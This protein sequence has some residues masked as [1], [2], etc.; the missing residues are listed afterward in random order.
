MVNM[1]ERKRLPFQTFDTAIQQIRR[2]Y[3]SAVYFW[4]T[5][6]I[7]EDMHFQ[8]RV[9]MQVFQKNHAVLCGI[10]EALAVLRLCSGLYS[11][12]K[13]AF[14][15]FDEYVARERIIRALYAERNYRILEQEQKRQTAAE[16]ELDELWVDKSGELEIQA[17]FDGDRIEPWETIMTIKGLPQYFAH[18]ESVYLGILARRTLVATNVSKVVQAANGKDV[19]FFADRFDF[20]RNQTGD[21]YAA[22]KAGVKAV[23]TDTMGEWWGNKGAGTTPHALIASFGGDTVAATLAFARKYPDVPCISLVDFKNNCVGTSLA[24]ADAFKS[25]GLPLWGVRLDTSEA[26]VDRSISH[27]HPRQMMGQEKPTGVNLMLVSNV[28]RALDGAGH[29]GVKIVVS[30]GFNEERIAYFEKNQAPVDAYGVGSSLL[31]GSNDFTADIVLLEGHRCAKAGRWW[32][33]NSRLER[34]VW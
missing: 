24:V 2:G 11:N 14:K 33:P 30:G 7:L 31:K 17:L 21:G 32:R 26:M 13:E 9:L 34:A 5:K 12:S 6:R 10:D 8:K 18:L 22:M 27:S 19:L 29:Q 4:R 20:Y 15:L 23:A 3:F 28:R 25:K 1:T 16:I